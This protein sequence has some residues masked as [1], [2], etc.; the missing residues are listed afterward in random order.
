[1]S[2]SRRGF[3][4]L[5]LSVMGCGYTPLLAPE[6]F[7]TRLQNNVDIIDRDGRE[8][9]EFRARLE[10]RLGRGGSSARYLVTYDYVVRDTAVTV[11][12]DADI[13]RFTLLGT[14]R[15]TV[16]DRD[17]GDVVLSDVIRA[18]AGYSTTSDTFPTRV[19]E[20]DAAI[21]LSRSLADQLVQLLQ[22]SASGFP[23]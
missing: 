12:E 17:S 16:T 18:S 14:V 2:W 3:V 8:N 10:E 1:M 23:A 21:R 4:L 15:F 13:E 22:L 5:G 7:A 11:S 6:T 20:R 19:A 9:F